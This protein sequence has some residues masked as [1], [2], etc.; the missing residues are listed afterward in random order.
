MHTKRL[1]STSRMNLG[2]SILPISLREILK[3]NPHKKSIKKFHK[4]KIEWADKSLQSLKKEIRLKLR[5]VQQNRCIYCRRIIK[6]DRRNPYEDIE[7]YLDK[8]KNCYRKWAFSNINLTLI[9]N[10]NFSF[11]ETRQGNN[12]GFV[13]HSWKIRVSSTRTWIWYYSG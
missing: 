5:T 12:V 6:I 13:R 4:R 3:K 8:S 7:H 9:Q 1:W 2:P 10:G 11:S